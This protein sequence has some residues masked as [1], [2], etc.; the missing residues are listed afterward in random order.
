M[1]L[2]VPD[3]DEDEVA[4]IAAALRA[5]AADAARDATDDAGESPRDRWQFAGRIESLQGRRVQVP[6]DAPRDEW[7]AAGR[8]DRF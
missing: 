7:L 6:A 2:D 3:A 5:I 1:E 4:A 8:T